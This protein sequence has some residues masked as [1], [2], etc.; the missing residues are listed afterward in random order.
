MR[1]RHND[2]RPGAE[3]TA[4]RDEP[5][6]NLT[7]PVRAVCDD[8]S[9]TATPPVRN[10]LSIVPLTPDR[11]ADLATLF[12]Q[13]GDPKWCWCASFYIHRRVKGVPP[14]VNRAIFTER[15]TRD[16]PPGLIAYRDRRAVGWVSVGPRDEYDKIADSKALAAIGGEAVWSV[17]CFVVARSERGQGIAGALLEAAVAFARAHGATTLEA[18]PADTR[19]TRIPS[20]NAY[21]GTLAMFERAGFS[22]VA[23][24][25]HAVN[26]AERPVVRRSL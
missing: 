3:L 17:V 6:R 25:P 11:I 16:R 9:V 7:R 26:T 24:L 22:E 23:R 15:A 19:G 13:P 2:E 20:P 18:Y 21:R 4:R 14:E 10:G 8:R 12:D 5:V 1:P